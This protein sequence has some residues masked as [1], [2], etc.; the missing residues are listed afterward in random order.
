MKRHLKKCNYVNYFGENRYNKIG[1][2][3]RKCNSVDI[4]KVK[5]KRVD[6]ILRQ[7]HS[8]GLTT[9]LNRY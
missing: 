1:Q 4:I 3:A 9:D 2:D 7:T 6:S 8:N 5:V